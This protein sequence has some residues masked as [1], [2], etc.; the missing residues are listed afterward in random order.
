[1]ARLDNCS[2]IFQNR[3]EEEEGDFVDYGWA[4]IGSF[5]DLD[6]IF[7]NDEPI[8][9]NVSLSNADDLW[10][11]SKDVASCPDTSMPL[12]MDVPSVGLGAF[13]STSEHPDVKTEYGLDQEQ[14]FTTA[15][16]KMNDIGCLPLKN[17]QAKMNQITYAG[18][19]SKLL[20]KDKTAS[21][22]IGKTAAFNPHLDA[23]PVAT[24]DNNADKLNRH[25]KLWK[26]Q[27]K[28]E[29]T[30][31]ARQLQELCGTWPSFGIQFQQFEG[32][33]APPMGLP[34][35]SLL[36]NQ[37]RL[38]Q[39]P[40]SLQYN[41]FS[42]PLLA[43]PVY[44]NMANQYP[45]LPVL[46]YF[47]S[48]ESNHQ[49]VPSGYDVSPGN[50]NRLNKTSG[51]P[52]KHLT[53]TP[54]EKIEKLRRRQQL[55]AMLAIQKQKQQFSHQVSCAE[56]SVTQKFSHENQMQLIPG[57]NTEDE[58]NLSTLPY[59]DPNSQVEQDDSNTVSM[60]IDDFSMEDTI[61][62]QLQ[63]VIAK[64][65]IQIRL[66]IRDSLF[67]LAQSAKKRQYASDTSSTNESS[68][69]EILAK[70]EINSHN[71]LVKQS[72]V[73]ILYLKIGYLYFA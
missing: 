54:Q 56:Q 4:N 73:L 8:F 27:K 69:D 16:A 3:Q 43:P 5:D 67:R 70:E 15:Y 66:C 22:M 46:Q 60:A 55:R 49:E 6:R 11:S 7:S 2:E 34:C 61:L 32:H 31:E 20:M 50:S 14:S 53:M 1:M 39:A 58:E 68:R 28:S 51:T 10:S 30:R 52:G 19:K 23:E 17:V 9:G 40:D 13:R 47:H 26:I 59:L 72:V 21:E 24:P 25:R 48:G 44:G 36:L 57:G 33:Y 12:S 18:G 65:D 37:K 29:E 71:R 63:K 41:H 42:N 35:P 45:T 38:L 64:L 62:H